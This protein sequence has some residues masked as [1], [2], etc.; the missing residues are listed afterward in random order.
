MGGVEWSGVEQRYSTRG[1]EEAGSV[2]ANTQWRMES[3][4]PRPLDLWEVRDN[5]V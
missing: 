4:S 2:I 5:S 3:P 1:V